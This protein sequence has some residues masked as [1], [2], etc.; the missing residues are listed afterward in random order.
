M[1]RI[2]G[3]DIT[4]KDILNTLRDELVDFVEMI[5]DEDRKSVV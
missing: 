5:G 4:V 1:R 3:M 2:E